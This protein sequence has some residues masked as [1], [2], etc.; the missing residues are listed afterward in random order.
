MSFVNARSGPVT[1]D[2]EQ[3]GKFNYL[4][5]NDRTKWETG[6][7]SY[8]DATAP[9]MYDGVSVRYSIDQGAPRYDVIVKP[10]VDASQ[11]GVKIDGADGLQVLPNGNLQIKT[12]L[13][14]VEE[15]GLTAYQDTPAGRVQV[16][17][18]MVLDGNELRFD[19]GG[20]DTAKEL[21]ID[22][23]VY[24]SY[25]GGSSTDG[26]LAVAVD[27]T[28]NIYLAGF[29]ES[30]DFP[31]TVGA[32]QTD[33]Y[34]AIDYTGTAFITK[35]NPSESSLIYST[36]L[37]GS[38]GD[39]AR[40]LA[41]D[42]EG[43][44]FVTGTTGSFDFPV[45]ADSFELYNNTFKSGQY[46]TTGF[47]SKLDPSGSGLVYS[48]YLGG[49]FDDEPAAIAVDSKG[50]AVVVGSTG[51]IDFPVSE[52]AFQ[53]KD[54]ANASPTGFVTKLNPTGTGVIY[55]TYLG[56][57]V[58]DQATCVGVDSAGNAVVAG[59]TYSPNFPIT[60]GVFQ[61]VFRESTRYPEYTGF[62]TKIN[63][64]GTS[65]VYSTFLG[66]SNSSIGPGGDFIGALAFDLSGNTILVGNTYASDF[67]VT[68]GAYQT[69]NKTQSEAQAGFVA[70]LNPTG[71]S[72]L[73]GSYISGNLGVEGTL[74]SGVSVDS[75]GNAVFAGS[76]DTTGYPITAGAIQTTGAG[77]VGDDNFRAGV[78][79]KLNANGTHLLY[80][81]L[82]GNLCEGTAVNSS[83]YAVV[84]GTPG[85]PFPTTSGA[86]E[87]VSRGNNFA[88][89]LNLV[90]GTPKL[91]QVT[92]TP[93]SAPGGSQVTGLV[94][95]TNSSSSAVVV[96]ISATGPVNFPSTVTVPD[97]S[98]TASFN[99]TTIGINT[100]TQA[101]ISATYGGQTLS[102]AVTVEPPTLQ[103][104]VM[105]LDPVVGGRA[106][107]GFAYLASV[108]AVGGYVVRL[109]SNDPLVT[110]PEGV[111]VLAGQSI[112]GFD[113]T[114]KP[115]SSNVVVTITGSANGVTVVSPLT[116][117]PAP[118]Q[119]F[120][121]SPNP[122]VGGVNS[123]A[124]LTLSGVAGP[125]GITVTMWSSS[126]LISI[127]ATVTVQPGKSTASFTITTKA[128]S[129]NT[130][131]YLHATAGSV[132]LDRSITLAP[133]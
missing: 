64:S 96:K 16:P 131:V 70:K 20:Y 84:I 114:T 91:G 115:V 82:F 59:L 10:G 92:V 15:R 4:L 102:A 105:Q 27:R 76:T 98:T 130:V 75:A 52:G 2:M 63:A 122:V 111:T 29:A 99:L 8:A 32:Y 113:I 3:D 31:T 69:I 86:F 95:L 94:S 121:V 73:Y 93:T 6:A 37:G 104:L 58:Q 30:S 120:T 107:V 129:T 87:P 24:S 112:R 17:C 56:G 1:G 74:L 40:G 26:A 106:D 110:V 101:T 83:Q 11:V 62:I 89:T 43:N 100:P 133:K 60:K 12:S 125:T 38:G 126:N 19:V 90:S 35:M 13:G 66:G 22:P 28:N 46:S 45:M 39:E 78:V 55:S 42:S 124:T 21:V 79:G 72:L 127:P 36:F 44:V 65:L 18:Q 97:G 51:S 34:E 5:G 67:P 123:S 132:I 117:V 33:N 41:V 80:S 119:N 14:A 68:T 118:L 108:A 85:T 48:T 61:T 128:V 9:N 77:Q 81:T 71:T 53:P 49:S 109:S 116:V 23:L 47:V 88:S 25:L 7:K 57:D 50:D 54:N 103:S